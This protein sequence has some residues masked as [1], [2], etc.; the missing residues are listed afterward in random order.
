MLRKLTERE[1]EVM[2]A[3]WKL[4]KAFVKEIISVL[5]DTQIPYNTISS[6]VRKLE[7]EG[8]IG[9]E[10][11]GNT[12]RYFPILKKSRYQRFMMKLFVQN[13][14]AGS[15]E[16]MLSYFMESEE[17]NKEELL[18]LVEELSKE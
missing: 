2:H 15:P 14:F 9:H 18:K 1:E 11:F 12:Y 7:K 17:V 10:S 6:V 13:Y 16:K 3:L 8:L 4:K 5:P